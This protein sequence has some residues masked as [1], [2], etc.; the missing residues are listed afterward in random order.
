MDPELYD[1][2]IDEADPPE[3]EVDPYPED[4]EQNLPKGV[5]IAVEPEIGEGEVV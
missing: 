1:D 2:G 3:E 4:E 5:D